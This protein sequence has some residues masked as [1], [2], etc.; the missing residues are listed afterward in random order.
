[1][2]AGLMAT[3]PASPEPITDRLTRLTGRWWRR[4]KYQWLNACLLSDLGAAVV[5]FGVVF[6]STLALPKTP[7]PLDSGA[8]G[9]RPS[10]PR[11]RRC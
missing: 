5:L 6:L 1:M 7:T 9:V 8:R 2:T 3:R 4:A 11:F 10:S